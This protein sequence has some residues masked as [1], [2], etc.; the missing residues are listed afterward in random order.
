MKKLLAFILFLIQFSVFAQKVKISGVA[1][2]F[3]LTEVWLLKKAD[4]ISRKE[5][6]VVE[7]KS[8]NKGNFEFEF[9]IEKTT[10]YIIRINE[11]NVYLYAEANKNYEVIFPKPGNAVPKTYGDNTFL[12]PQFKN[13]PANDLNFLISDFDK[14][15]K[16]FLSEFNYEIVKKDMA[17][18]M[19]VFKNRIEKIYGDVKNEYFSTYIDYSLAGL[20]SIFLNRKFLFDNYFK[21]KTIPYYNHE[22]FN[23]FDEHYKDYIYEIFIKKRSKKIDDIINKRRDYEAV[24]KILKEDSLLT[25][26]RF[27]ELILLKSLKD[28][29]YKPEFKKEAILNLLQI[30]SYNSKFE[31]HK[32]MAK[33]IK[34]QLTSGEVGRI[35]PPFVLSDVEQKKYSLKELNKKPVYLFFFASWNV[36]SQRE[37][38]NLEQFSKKYGRSYQFVAVSLDAY[39]QDLKQYLKNK[40]FSF[41]ILSWNDFRQ[42]KY[43]YNVKSVPFAFI[44]NEGRFFK[45]PALLPMEGLENDLI[46]LRKTSLKGKTTNSGFRGAE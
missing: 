7:T 14:K 24:I 13:L 8:D 46:Q 41:P 35:A 32:L 44:I 30:L 39:T 9:D 29:Y 42:I 37:L 15:Y 22:Y 45:S 33:N 19:K 38:E 27:C 5:Q 17:R 1:Q 40:K 12:E 23:F 2:S 28:L 36:E 26:D 34:D 3:P 31:E 18:P 10:Q 16:S 20:E 25:D 4:F 6:K 11:Y 43:D 21:N